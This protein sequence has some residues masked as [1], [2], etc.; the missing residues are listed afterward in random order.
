MVLNIQFNNQMSFSAFP[1]V[2]IGLCMAA[3]LIR[4]PEILPDVGGRDQAVS[5]RWPPKDGRPIWR[6]RVALWR[7]WMATGCRRTDSQ[8]EPEHRTRLRIA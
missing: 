2:Q 1:G 6:Q 3:P 5:H 4:F 7:C 8:I